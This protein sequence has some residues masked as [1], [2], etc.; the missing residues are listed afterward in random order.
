MELHLLHIICKT[1]ED[2]VRPSAFDMDDNNYYAIAV[3]DGE[4]Y[5]YWAKGVGLRISA[6]EFQLVRKN[7]R[8]YYFSTALK[9]HCRINKLI[10]SDKP[11]S[12]QV[13]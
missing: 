12:G 11:L 6:D 13:E 8:L 1:Q 10:N 7:P 5:Y 9:L 4:R 3:E 2:D